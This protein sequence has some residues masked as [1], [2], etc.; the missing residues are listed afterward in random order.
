VIEQRRALAAYKAR[1]TPEERRRISALL[2]GADPG[3]GAREIRLTAAKQLPLFETVLGAFYGGGTCC[4]CEGE[5][6][7]EPVATFDGRYRCRHVRC[8]T[9]ERRAQERAA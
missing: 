4:F 6:P 1:T 8:V 5:L 3:A 2:C 7:G 9:A